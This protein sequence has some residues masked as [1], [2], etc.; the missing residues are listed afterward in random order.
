MIRCVSVCTGEEECH[1]II[2]LVPP[3]VVIVTL[4]HSSLLLCADLLYLSES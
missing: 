1:L 2:V 4:C 3:T